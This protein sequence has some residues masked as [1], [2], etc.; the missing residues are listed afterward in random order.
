MKHPYE[1]QEEIERIENS[2]YLHIDEWDNHA[3]DYD[4]VR[5]Y[6]MYRDCL[7]AYIINIEDY[8]SWLTR[9]KKTVQNIEKQITEYKSGKNKK[10]FSDEYYCER[11]ELEVDGCNMALDFVTAE[12]TMV[13]KL[14]NR[15]KKIKKQIRELM[16]K[17]QDNHNKIKE[18][19]EWEK[20]NG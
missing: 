1:V 4:R 11:A 20:H 19:K 12:S 9:I 15:N 13:T 2:G 3:S 5:K 6:G 8:N 18:I 7:K 14:Q 10:H 17:E 16:Q